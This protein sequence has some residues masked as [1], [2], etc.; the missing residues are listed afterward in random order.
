MKIFLAL[1][2]VSTTFMSCTREPAADSTPE[3]RV[4]VKATTVRSGSIEETVSA[5]GSTTIQREAQLRSPITGVLVSFKLYNGDKVKKGEPVAEVRTK[6]SQASLQGA[7]ELLRSAVT[8]QQRDE[9]QKAVRLA[10]EIGRAH[11]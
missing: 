5:T 9:A 2:F 11:V 6:E 10:Q 4:E 8:P 1:V 7:E 3:V